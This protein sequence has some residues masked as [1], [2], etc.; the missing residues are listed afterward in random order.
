MMV[1]RRLRSQLWMALL[2]L[3]VGAALIATPGTAQEPVVGTWTIMV[4]ICADNSTEGAAVGSC[5]VS[6]PANDLPSIVNLMEMSALSMYDVDGISPAPVKA[7]VQLD[8]II[9]ASGT[10]WDDNT[11]NDWESCHRFRVIQDDGSGNPFTDIF[12]DSDQALWNDLGEVDMASPYSL[13]D[14]VE[15]ASTTYPADHYALFL[16]DYTD[17][18][19]SRPYGASPVRWLMWD[20][21]PPPDT[22]GWYYYDV[23][24]LNYALS[25]VRRVLGKKLDVLALDTDAMGTVEAIH[26]LRDDVQYIVA[27]EP[28]W[29]WDMGD[30]VSGTDGKVYGIAGGFWYD[31]ILDDLVSYPDMPPRTFADMT[32]WYSG[33]WTVTLDAAQMPALTNSLTTFANEMRNAFNTDPNGPLASMVHTYWEIAYA[34]WDPRELSGPN[35]PLG[36]V[37]YID[38]GCFAELMATTAPTEALRNAANDLV[39]KLQRVVLFP[40]PDTIPT[41]TFQGL[42]IMHPFN[43]MPPVEYR[44]TWL[45]G[46]TT[47]DEWI[48]TQPLGWG[49]YPDRF[50]PDGSLE[51]ATP[52]NYG[53]DQGWHWFDR[54]DDMDVA[55]FAAQEGQLY[56]VGT[57]HQGPLS[58]PYM[59]IMTSDYRLLAEGHWP[60]T[61]LLWLCPKSGTYYIVTSQSDLEDRPHATGGWTYYSVWAVPIR[62]ADVTPSHWAFRQVAVCQL[63]GLVSGYPGGVYGPGLAV[64]REQMAV[65]IAR[66][67]CQGDAN[68]PEGP[69][70]PSF[71]DVP[72]DH[73]AY[74]YIEYAKAQGVVG[75]YPTGEYRPTK[76]VDRAQMAVFIARALAGGDASVPDDFS[77]RVFRDVPVNHWA[78]QYVQYIANAGVSTGY[79]DRTYRPD[80]TC[81]RDQ[82]AVFVAR[83]FLPPIA[84]SPFAR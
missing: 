67:L 83:A 55:S 69:M 77:G 17:D 42:A 48:F 81:T 32:A 9:P 22:F 43:I 6:P 23:A 16:W 50:E 37:D 40:S 3:A 8:R 56:A 14:F 12:S 76:P 52:I 5:G 24:T 11:N 71:P 31:W 33:G 65:Y 51:S 73:W 13:I 64:T 74:K 53:Y 49:Y 84:A 2:L 38:L 46:E 62:L 75:G 82:M 80:L 4:Y 28:L 25:G 20:E 68:V 60:S 41:S 70:S 19:V 30:A 54:P 15:W 39:S 34:W 29:W 18:W 1:K 7:V 45:A 10:A 61:F 35:V 27:A 47:W 63:E 57:S 59:A 78:R 79:G 26:C 58:F 72:A 44:Y 21:T 36:S 66:A